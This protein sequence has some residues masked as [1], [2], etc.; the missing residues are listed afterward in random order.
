MGRIIGIDYG[1]K[2]IGI[3]VTDP[4]KIIATGLTTVHSKDI[5]NFLNDYFNKEDV[6]CLVIGY[7]KDL[8][9]RVQGTVTEALPNTLFRVTLENEG[10]NEIIAHLAGKLRLHRIRVMAGDRVTLELS[11]QGDKGRIVYRG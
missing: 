1:T 7:P 9:N 6:E 5:F 11:P 4:F 2:R 10:E 8:K 3:A